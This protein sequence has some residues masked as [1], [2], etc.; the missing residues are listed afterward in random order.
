MSTE[1]S[2]TKLRTEVTPFQLQST[3]QYIEEQ[4]IMGKKSKKKSKKQ[5]KSKKSKKTVE[6]TVAKAA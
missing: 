2:E 3:T 1:K 5:S 4:N 6:D